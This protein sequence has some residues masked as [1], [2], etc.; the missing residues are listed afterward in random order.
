M[1]LICLIEGKPLAEQGNRLLSYP[2]A[3][4]GSSNSGIIYNNQP[5]AS[6]GPKR[7]GKIKRL[8]EFL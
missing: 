7:P 6:D 8:V 4:G 2:Q 5:S 1:S 3:P